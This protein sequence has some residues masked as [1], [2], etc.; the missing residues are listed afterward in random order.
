MT[1]FKSR[2]IREWGRDGEGEG[3][4]LINLNAKMLHG[5]NKEPEKLRDFLKKQI[6]R[7]LTVN[8]LI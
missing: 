6:D 4:S 3:Y 5:L 1:N 2:L 7:A 8:K